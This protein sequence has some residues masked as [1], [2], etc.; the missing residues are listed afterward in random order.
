MYHRCS[1]RNDGVV[2]GLERGKQGAE[3]RRC[4]EGS[5]RF[6]VESRKGKRRRL[7]YGPNAMNVFLDR[8]PVQRRRVSLERLHRWIQRSERDRQREAEETSEERDLR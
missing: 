8:G 1:D 4:D 7:R 5:Q 3:I 6:V 2:K